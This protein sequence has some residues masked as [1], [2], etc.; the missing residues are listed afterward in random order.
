MAVLFLSK[1]PGQAE[2][3]KPLLERE[4]PDMEIRTWPSEAGNLADITYAVVGLPEPGVLQQCPNLKAILSTWAGVDRLLADPTLPRHLPLSRMVDPLLTVDM[5]HFA[6]H[7]VIHFHRNIHRHL[8]AQREGRWEQIRYPEASRRRVGI[9][10]LGH[11]GS[12]AARRL[13]ALGFDVGGWDA[14]PKQI[15]GVAAFLGEAQFVPFLNRT[16][17]LVSLLPLTAK[18]RGI[19][20]ARSLAALPEGAYVISIARGGHIV[21]AD[22]LAALDAGH[23]AGAAL[24]S[25]NEEPLPPAHPYWRHSKVFVTPH[26]A[27]LTTPRTAAREVAID[28]R[29]LERGELPRHLVDIERGY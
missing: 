22:L 27:S 19:L 20:N 7:W 1:T 26:V 5:S 16:D 28:I 21:D 8:A 2:I 25:F 13:A 18:T 24:D 6:I 15:E 29:R 14:V 17:I 23:I 4:L 11:L 3:Y 9:M 10:G 12:D